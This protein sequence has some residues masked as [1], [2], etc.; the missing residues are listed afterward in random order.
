MIPADMRRVRVEL[1]AVVFA[2]LLVVSV[3][4]G[5][6]LALL[7][8]GWDIYTGPSLLLVVVLALLVVSL[9]RRVER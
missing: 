6:L 4:V 8:W 2:L 5:I 3:L 7:P 1:V 9:A